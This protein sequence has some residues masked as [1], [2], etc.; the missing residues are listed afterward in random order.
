M[1]RSVKS[2]RKRGTKK[3]VERQALY[4]AECCLEKKA[5]EV[6]VLDLKK[7]SDMSDF[8]VICEGF[9]DIHVRSVAENVIEGLEKKFSSRPNHVEGL[10]N[11]R[12]VLIDYF[13]FV[14]HVFQPQA[15]RFYQLERL[16]ADAPV[17]RVE[18]NPQARAP[19]GTG[20]SSRA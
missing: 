12:W 16:W 17:R 7:L 1:A 13:D 2:A 10:E 6:V 9:T 19:E 4:A 8:F 15:R 14:V 3:E 11:G 18:D 5:E 20:D